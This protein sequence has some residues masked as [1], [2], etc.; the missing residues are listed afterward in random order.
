M[1][2]SIDA[3]EDC[4][5]YEE[6]YFV[7]KILDK[8]K[9]K[10][11]W[12]YKVKWVGFSLDECTWEPIENLQTCIELIEEFDRKRETTKL[13]CKS[14]EKTKKI[15][16]IIKEEIPILDESDDKK[17]DL[18]PLKKQKTEKADNDSN[19]LNQGEIKK[20]QEDILN[21]NL[22]KTTTDEDQTNI[23]I[24]GNFNEDIAFKIVQAK[25]IDSNLI[26]LN[27]LIEWEKRK[28]GIKPSNTWI[29][30]K[31]IYEKDPRLLLRFYETKIKFP[32]LDKN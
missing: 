31:E 25:I 30:S 9:Y 32:S 8:K 23:E 4:T 16:K 11:V 21:S 19:E 15:K 18:K 28:D 13:N 3:F 5:S 20:I 22:S 10:D 7:E 14:P 24:L 26:E 2:C 12:K 29:S 6:E 27:C 1:S 17:E